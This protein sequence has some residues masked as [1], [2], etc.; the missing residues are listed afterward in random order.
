MTR[1]RLVL[2]DGAC[3]EG[4]VLGDATSATG[5]VVFNTAM[6][7]YEEAIT[8][9][10]YAG[11]V[12]V[13]TSPHVG[14][15]GVTARDA[16]SERI[17]PRAV[18]LNATPTAP[19]NYASRQSLAA[20]LNGKGVPALCGVDTRRLVLHLRAHGTQMGVIGTAPVA[21]ASNGPR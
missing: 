11:Q 15:T 3:F 13:F 9:P 6:L 16:E 17:Q 21:Y 1:A 18:V 19:S 20:W 5:E 7:G 12:L 14:N 2:A 8:D 4:T 10:S